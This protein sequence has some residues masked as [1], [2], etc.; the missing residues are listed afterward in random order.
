MVGGRHPSESGTFTAGFEPICNE[1]AESSP[2]KD[3][4]SG[5]RPA[6][7]QTQL[8]AMIPNRPKTPAPPPPSTPGHSHGHHPPHPKKTHRRRSMRTVRRS[9]GSNAGLIIVGII[10]AVGVLIA[11]VVAASK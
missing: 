6:I 1:C 4:S 5:S 3:P 8:D 11:L 10:L 7:S 9:S 2:G